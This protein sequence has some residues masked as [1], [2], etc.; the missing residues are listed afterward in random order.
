MSEMSERRSIQFEV[1]GKPVTQGSKN[2]VVPKY[3]DGTLL[4]RHKKSCPGSD[5]KEMAHVFAAKPCK[6]P[7]MVNVVEDNDDDLKA[8]KETVGWRAKEAMRGAPL[9]DGLVIGVFEFVLPRPKGHYGTGRNASILKDSAPAAPG[10]RPDGVKLARSIEDAMTG[11]VYTDDSL[12]V[13][14]L[15]SKRYCDRLEPTHMRVRII[16]CRAQTVGDLVAQGKL[17][18]PRAEETFEQL[19]LLD[20]LAEVPRQEAA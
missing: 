17:K 10:S 9:I 12:I 11:I 5:S 18:M 7:A 19:G 3:G 4:R 8:W 20:T 1:P 6:C 14:H 13:T 16:E 2:P 15:I